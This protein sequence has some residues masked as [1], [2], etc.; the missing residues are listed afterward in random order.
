MYIHIH[1]YIHISRINV[2]RILTC[3]SATVSNSPQS[4]IKSSFSMALICTT[5][6]RI[7]ASASTHQGSEIVDW[8]LAGGRV[9]MYVPSGAET[10]HLTDSG[11]FF[12]HCFR[13]QPFSVEEQLLYGNMKR[14]RGGLVRKAHRPLYQSNLGLRV[15]KNTRRFQP[16]LKTYPGEQDAIGCSA[17]TGGRGQSGE[18]TLRKY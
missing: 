7:P 12:F 17:D 3:E 18:S 9:V 5:S 14:F 15:I 10:V 13:F 6:R 2:R 1:L 11:A 16:H 4:G 8:A